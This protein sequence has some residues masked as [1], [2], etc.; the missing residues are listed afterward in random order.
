MTTQNNWEPCPFCK[1]NKL[2]VETKRKHV[3]YNGLDYSVYLLSAS[4]RCNCCHARGPVVS[5]KVIP[6]LEDRVD[7]LPDWATTEESLIYEA[8]CRWN[9]GNEND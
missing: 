1:K 4:V 3:G 2:K 5:G 8:I 6:I 9:G 7:K